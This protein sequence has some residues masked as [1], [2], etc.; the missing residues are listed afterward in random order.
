MH[1]QADSQR[2][3]CS[4][5]ACYSGLRNR[6]FE[7]KRL[8]ADAFRV[9]Q[10]YLIDRRRLLNRAIHGWGVVYGFAIKAPR[11]E[12]GEGRALGIG[13]GLALDACGRELVRVRAGAVG[14]DAVV[15]LDAKGRR[16]SPDDP[17]RRDEKEPSHDRAEC[18]DD[19]WLLSVHYAE[20]PMDPVDLH[21]PCSCER[22]EWD[23]VCET[24]RFS[25]RPIRCD[26]CCATEECGLACE[27]G[28]GPCCDE[29]ANDKTAREA[30]RSATH[31]PRQPVQRGG[32]R[33]LCDHLTGLQLDEDC[34]CLT[35][36]DERCGRVRVDLHHGV[37]LACVKL[38]RDD[39]GN[40]GFGDDVE[41]CGPRRLVKRNDLLFDLIRGC[42]LTRISAIGW[43]PWH[44]RDALVDY[45][46][47][48][49]SFG[50]ENPV[51]SGRN[52]T[53]DYWVEFSRP[54]RVD[55]VKPDCFSMTVT[56]AEDEAG[57]GESRR[58][59]I[60]DVITS[61]GPDPQH[62]T[63]AVLVVEAGW[64]EDATV[65]RHK[66]FNKDEALV[67]IAVFG[68]FIIDCN[69]QAVDAN[70]VGL[71]PAPTGNGTPGGTFHSN[72]RVAQSDA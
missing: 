50:Q 38:Q 48:Q 10:D 68:D 6:Y 5:E 71:L 63:R 62:I 3:C 36:I 8:T 54:V 9:E 41:A 46:D 28:T 4:D 43:A 12:Q 61:G 21:D 64:A 16:V 24:V 44:R 47:F 65:K 11:A 72:F 42:D 35:E 17:D 15:V 31:K 39:C 49:A 55:T 45:G 22:K 52:V 29:H 19:C 26:A 58:V 14:L 33:C 67:E 25:L 1:R 18:D 20:Q 13:S 60:I 2:E 30:E 56:I 23:H 40:W 53:R 51:K 69:G 7:G 66:I 57:W 27:C 32:C 37:P 70:A 34:G 59:P